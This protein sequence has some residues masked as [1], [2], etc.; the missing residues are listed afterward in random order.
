MNIKKHYL[1]LAS[2]LFLVS[3]GCSDPRVNPRFDRSDL[4]V[5]RGSVILQ[6]PS[7]PVCEHENYQGPTI[8]ILRSPNAPDFAPRLEV[9]SQPELFGDLGRGLLFTAPYVF[10]D[11]PT[12]EFVIQSVIDGDLNFNPF[13]PL[14]AQ[15]TSGDLVGGF[16]D[17]NN[18][19]AQLTISEPSTYEQVIVRAGQ[20]VPLE[21]PSF[22]L[23]TPRVQLDPE[24]GGQIELSIQSLE[25]LSQKPECSA[26]LVRTQPSQEN[27]I[28]LNEDGITVFPSVTLISLN[29]DAAIFPAE[30]DISPLGEQSVLPLSAITVQLPSGIPS[31]NYQIRLDTGLGQNWNIPN[32]L[33]NLIPGIPDSQSAFLIIE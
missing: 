4:S 20:T 11:I 16:V 14:L 13:V 33:S 21:P 6:P 30:I 3:Y 17:E 22:R 12:G 2:L 23:D 7:E 24:T 1:H 32:L 27:D 29:D 15:P 9:I 31:G 19:P 5:V 8:L 10:P 26:F 25:A 18:Q 28:D